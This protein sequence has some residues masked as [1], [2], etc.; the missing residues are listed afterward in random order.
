MPWIA[1]LI[2]RIVVTSGSSTDRLDHQHVAVGLSRRFNSGIERSCQVGRSSGM[3]Y[4]VSVV[5]A[6]FALAL[7]AGMGRVE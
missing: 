2:R 3:M 4:V 6:V 1:R 7:E 5:S